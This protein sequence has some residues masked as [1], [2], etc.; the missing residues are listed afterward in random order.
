MIKEQLRKKL[1]SYDSLLVPFSLSENGR[2]ATVVRGGYRCAQKLLVKTGEL[3]LWQ[4]TGR[5]T[6]EPVGA[7]AFH[8]S[9][10]FN[11]E[12]AAVIR[13]KGFE[14]TFTRQKNSGR[15]YLGEQVLGEIV[16]STKMRILSLGTA[17]ISRGGEK[18]ATLKLPAVGPSTSQRNDCTGAFTLESGRTIPFVIQS[19]LTT[20][21]STSSSL[22]SL[23]DKGIFS[24]RPSPR[25]SPILPPEQ[26][27]QAE[28][29]RDNTL[30]LLLFAVAAWSRT[31][32]PMN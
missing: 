5:D 8:K 24:Y 23:R 16:L 27:E 4:V 17:S 13:C 1:Q 2:C 31:L 20:E 7:L 3:S 12:E 30:V 6:V 21:K 32:Y 19:K 14:L 18:I 25:K 9:G 26:I 10:L 28:L 22:S 11:R 15:W 29:A